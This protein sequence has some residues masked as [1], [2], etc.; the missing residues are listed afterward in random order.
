MGAGARQLEVLRGSQRLQLDV[1]LAERPHKEDSLVDSVDP[2][3]NLISRLGI[4]GVD[5][6]PD[7]AT[8]CPT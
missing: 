4:L 7:L 1:P 3:K 8:R 2:V 6:N 5:L